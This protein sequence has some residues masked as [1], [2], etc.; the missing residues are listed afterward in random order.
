MKLFAYFVKLNLIY[1]E[2]KENFLFIVM[3]KNT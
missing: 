1:M 3:V 2:Q